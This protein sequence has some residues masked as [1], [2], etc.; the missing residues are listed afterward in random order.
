MVRRLALLAG[1][2]LLAP[3]L[4]AAPLGHP[5]AEEPAGIDAVLGTLRETPYDLEMLISFGTSKFGSA[6]HLA[7][8]VRDGAPGDDLVYSANFYADGKPDHVANHY[9]EEL[10]ARIPKREYLFGKR[11]SL[12]PKASFGLDYGEVYKRSV[13]GIRI[14]GVDPALTKALVAFWERVNADYKAGASDTDYQSGPVLYDYMKL[15]CAKTIALAFKKGAGFR[16]VRVKG[17]GFFSKLNPLKALEANVPM[18]VA[19]DIL[20][21]GAK[22][23]WTFDAVLYKKFEGSTYV[24]PGSSDPTTFGDLPDRFPSVLSLDYTQVQGRY[25]DH[26]NLRAMNLLF[27]LG[28]ASVVVNGETNRVEIE[29]TKEPLSYDEADRKAHAAAKRDS[30]SLLRRL[31]FRSWGLRLG[32]RADNRHLYHGVAPGEP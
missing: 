9:T 4:L 10:M 1:I 12:G 2:A 16:D 13:I 22:R 8:A 19:L 17:E 23:D 18:E 15:N 21:A 30:K 6:G 32:K 14:G 28:S 25:E 29:K 11:S 26:D 7:M 24:I 3:P 5:A 20:E 31:L 27:H